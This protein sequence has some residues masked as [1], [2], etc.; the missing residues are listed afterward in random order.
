MK[1]LMS[2][3]ESAASHF[4]H[5]LQQPE[6]W[7]YQAVDKNKT[8][9]TPPDESDVPADDKPAFLAASVRSL[10]AILSFVSHDA[11]LT[12]ADSLFGALETLVLNAEN[13]DVVEAAS[14]AIVTLFELL[15]L[16]DP[17]KEHEDV[18]LM[19]ERLEELANAEFKNNQATY[20]NRQRWERRKAALE[21]AAQGKVFQ[22]TLPRIKLSRIDRSSWSQRLTPANIRA[23]TDVLEV[24]WALGATL[25]FIHD[26][27]G[28]EF[29]DQV[30][31]E[32]SELN[33]SFFGLID[34]FDSWA[35]PRLRVEQTGA[36]I[37][38]RYVDDMQWATKV[39]GKKDR[40]Y[41]LVGAQTHGSF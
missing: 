23:K 21:E 25:R 35:L 38:T 40:K 10:E 2:I 8:K 34:E 24:S 15:S 5:P 9:S 12:R 14:S 17:E 32:D 36:S 7:L 16:R 18:T 39:A 19:V 6:A 20:D 31:K 41:D 13:E 22:V 29:N 30:R 11:L 27:I 3:A 26:L 1:D 28:S 37:F 33:H 4:A